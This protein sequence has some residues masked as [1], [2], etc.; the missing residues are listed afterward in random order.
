MVLCFLLLSCVFAHAQ[1]LEE[2]QKQEKAKLQQFSKDQKEGQ[3]RLKKD[4]ADYVAKRD[5]EWADYLNQEWENYSIF[6]GS[7]VSQ[8]PKPQTIPVYTPPT[9]AATKPSVKPETDPSIKPK[10]NPVVIL[11][12]SLPQLVVPIRKP[13]ARE[14]NTRIASFKFY[15]RSFSIPFDVAFGQFNSAIVNQKSISTFWEEAS[16]TNYTPIVECLL[17]AKADLN[18]NDYGYYLLVQQFAKELYPTSK[19]QSCLI[20]WFILVRSGYGVRVAFQDSEVALLLPSVQEVCDVDYLT[21]EGMK[22]YIFPKLRG[23]T[24]QTYAQ[25]YPSAGRTIDFT[26]GS[27]INF[28][29]RKANRELTFD[30]ENTPYRLNIAYDPDLIDFY[31]EYPSVELNTYFNAAVS[32]QT[33]ESLVSALKPLIANMDELKSVNFLLRF[34]QTAFGYKTDNEQFGREKYFFA[35]ELFYYPYCD[36]EDRAVLFSYLVRE[37]VGL[38]VVGLEYPDHV[39]TAVAFTIPKTGES[40][41]YNKDRYLVADPTY[42]NA[43]VGMAM[44]QYQTVSP[45]IHEI[46]NHSAEE[47]LAGKQWLMAENAGCHKGSNQKNSKILSDGTS[48]LTG[49]FSNSV[50][51]GEISLSGIPNTHNC[52]V[53]K[54]SP[55]GQALWAKAISATGNAV[56]MSVETTPSG[57]VIVAGTFTDSIRFAGKCISTAKGK[58]DLFIASFSSTGTF[59]WLHRGDLE[60]LPQNVTTAFSVSINSKGIKSDTKYADQQL[61]DQSQGLFVDEKGEVLYSGMISNTLALAGNNKLASLA[62]TSA[63]DVIE[64][65]RNE[66]EKFVSRQADQAIAGLLAA[67]CL[68]KDM[69]ISFT[70]IQTQQALDKNNP[71]FRKNCPNIYKNLGKINFVKNAKGVIAIQTENGK[72]ISFDKVCISNNSTISISELPEGDYKVDVLSGIKVGKMV[73]WYNLNYIKMLTKNGNLMFDYASDHSHASVN[74]RKDILN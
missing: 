58:A 9:G 5:R 52:F 71:N 8:K 11:P 68:V 22:Y 6:S 14:S 10:G 67:I 13:V 56:G 50:Q 27:P 54:I 2:Y 7:K 63:V 73:V 3:E 28:C 20:A 60:T 61:D 29:G 45:I 47:L 17:E 31:K 53:A 69:G 32:V 43:P 33:K 26:I 21:F 55:N 49:Y 23:T 15:G 37:L 41:V 34:V 66:S 57:N 70:G 44:P 65:L 38:K 48:L 35:D 72:D 36:C 25:D 59:Q 19:S 30:F 40:L 4:Y 64:L 62:S 16:N 24:I 74:I 42:I 18:I 12:E 39:A 51:L 1:S 46:S